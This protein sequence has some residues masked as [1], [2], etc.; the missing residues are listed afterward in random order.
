M[1]N[2][3]LVWAQPWRGPPS[4][5]YDLR[6]PNVKHGCVPYINLVLHFTNMHTRRGALALQIVQHCVENIGHVAVAVQQIHG[7]RVRVLRLAETEVA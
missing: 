5:E 2:M 6:D 3:K 1:R 4:S 7:E